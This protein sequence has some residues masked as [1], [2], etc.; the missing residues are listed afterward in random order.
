MAL[1][2]TKKREA[3]LEFIRKYATV[4]RS[5]P[6]TKANLDEAVTAVE[7]WVD[8]NQA[9]FVSHLAANAATFATNA[10]AAEKTDVLIQVLLKRAE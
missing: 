10:S 4:T 3:W 9:S 6:W 1:T 5:I 2:S 7:A 8:L